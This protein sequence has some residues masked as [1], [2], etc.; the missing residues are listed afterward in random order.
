MSTFHFTFN[1]ESWWYLSWAFFFFDMI[2]VC[3]IAHLVECLTVSCY[4][5]WWVDYFYFEIWSLCLVAGLFGWSWCLLWLIGG[6]GTLLI[7]LI[8]FL[9]EIGSRCLIQVCFGVILVFFFGGYGVGRWWSLT[10]CWN[11][12]FNYI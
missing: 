9:F 11:R 4:E 6:G 10:K 5:F 2:Y 1:L 7:C 12:T 3:C 8:V